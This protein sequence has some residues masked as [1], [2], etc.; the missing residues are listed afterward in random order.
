MSCRLYNQSEACADR[1]DNW[2]RILPVTLI[3]AGVPAAI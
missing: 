1:A 3:R 2:T